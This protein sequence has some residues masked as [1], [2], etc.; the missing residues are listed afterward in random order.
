MKI[1]SLQFSSNQNII[2]NILNRSPFQNSTGNDRDLSSYRPAMKKAQNPTLPTGIEKST[3]PQHGR[4]E[5]I[6][7]SNRSMELLKRHYL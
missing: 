1:S 3:T 7:I 2:I 5:R 4:S 6:Q